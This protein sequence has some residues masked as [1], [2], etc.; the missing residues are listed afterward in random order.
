[1]KIITFKTI[2]IS[3]IILIGVSCTSNQAKIDFNLI[4]VKSG[5]K[6]G[7]IN[8]K[9]EYVINPQF[10]NAAF[11]R[12]GLARVVAS[13]DKIGYISE[14]GKFK[15]PAKFKDG[16]H[17]SE[18]LAFVVSDGGYPTCIDNSGETKF[19]LKQAKLAFWFTEGLAMFM[20]TENKFGFVDKLGKVIVNPQFDY[21]RPFSEG[22]AA[23]CQNEKWGFIDKTGKIIINPQFEGVADFHNGEAVFH[24][25]KQCGFINTQGSYV[26]NPQF[27]Y[28]MSFSEGMAA[29]YSGKQFGYIKEDGKIEINPQFEEANSFYSDLA[30]IKLG[31]KYGY[32]NKTGKIEINPQF[33]N[34][35]QFFGDI[36]FVETAEKWGIIDKKGKYLVN[37]Q[38]DEIPIQVSE[39]ALENK[40]GTDVN[41]IPVVKTDF[42]DTS[43]FTN[44]LF[45][46]SSTNSFYGFTSNTTLQNIVDNTNYGDNLT[47][48]TEYLAICNKSQKITDDISINRT[49]FHFSQPIYT[50]VSDGWYGTTKQYVFSQKISAI[51]IEF[52]LSGDANDKGGAIANGLKTEIENRYGLNLENINGNYVGYQD[53]GKLSFAIVNSDYSVTLYISFAKEKLQEILTNTDYENETGE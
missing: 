52:E 37:P 2:V 17:F 15:I 6:W 42:Y 13:D 3:W 49:S 22:F 38:F 46:K 10:K 11:F 34:A 48:I 1:M 43:T 51:E 28:A 23:I 32:I 8:N 50:L 33:D 20:N 30:M 18:D 36:A 39:Y 53:N 9:G 24:N 4:P 5:E 25:G 41:N 12:C 26:I 19:H 40:F 16:T 31:D 14:D 35:S 44:K 27:E 47:A 29:I 45:E 7:Y 21:A